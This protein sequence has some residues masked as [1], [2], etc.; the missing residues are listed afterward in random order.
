MVGP[1]SSGAVDD[2][3][4]LNGERICTLIGLAVLAFSALVLKFDVGFTALG[5][6][7]VLT[8]AFPASAKGA[9][10][11]VAWG[12]RAARGR[13]RDLCDPAAGAGHGRVA[14]Q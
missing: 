5:V 8:L 9:V 7:V 11:K 3:A 1:R 14:G 10:D 12:H 4:R 6:A 2:D 13:H